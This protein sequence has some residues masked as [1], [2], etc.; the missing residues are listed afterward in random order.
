MSREGEVSHAR[1]IETG[2]G[3]HTILA[4]DLRLWQN[5]L[6]RV[7]VVC[8]RDWVVQDTDRLEQMSCHLCLLREVTRVCNDLLRLRLKRHALVLV[9]ALMH[10]CLDPRDPVSIVL[11]LVNVRVEHVSASV[12]GGETSET[13]RELA[14]T[15]EWV[16]V[17]GLAIPGHGVDVETDALDGVHGLP[18]GCEVVVGGVEGHGVADEVTRASLETELVVDFFHRCRS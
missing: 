4:A 5:Q 2:Q 7:A 17:W 10:G 3:Q 6:Q 13:L 11:D 8:V 15:V 1:E 14:K 9:T 16:D 18:T 12:D